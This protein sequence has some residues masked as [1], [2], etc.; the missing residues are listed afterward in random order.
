MNKLIQKLISSGSDLST[1]KALKK[2]MSAIGAN[3]E[4]IDKIYVDVKNS[5]HNEEF[6]N[7]PAK[8]KIIFLPQCMR[9]PSKCKAKLGKYGYEC[10]HCGSCKI[11]KI[12]KEGEKRGYRIFIAP[13]GSMVF[14]VIKELQPKAALGVACLKELVMA[15]EEIPIPT[16]SVELSRDGCIN[17]DVD[18]RKVLDKMDGHAEEE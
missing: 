3:P 2:A 15:H 18:I 6:R 14:K 17:T 10:Q 4:N 9:H 5:I 1:R 16:Q 12:V 11:T 13:G 7:I 8:D